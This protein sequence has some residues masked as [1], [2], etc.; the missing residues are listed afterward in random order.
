[1][2]LAP[3]SYPEDLQAK[4]VYLPSCS[5]RVQHVS[6]VWVH[7]EYNI[8]LDSSF[9]LVEHMVAVKIAVIEVKKLTI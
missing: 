5:P 3:W 6:A 7:H 4:I 9:L 1:M 2:K 8:V